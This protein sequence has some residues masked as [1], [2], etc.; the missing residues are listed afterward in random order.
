M[1]ET[2]N[3]SEARAEKPNRVGEV[4]RLAPTGLRNKTGGGVTRALGLHH[5]G[6]PRTKVSFITDSRSHRGD[7]ATPRN[8]TWGR[9]RGK[10]PQLPVCFSSPQTPATRLAVLLWPHS[11]PVVLTLTLLPC[12]KLGSGGPHIP[13]SPDPSPS[14]QRKRPSSQD[15]A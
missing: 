7:A 13:A 2:D 4:T 9:D 14:S 1:Q 3:T 11:C 10:M 15:L 5:P 12:F 8:A 6:E